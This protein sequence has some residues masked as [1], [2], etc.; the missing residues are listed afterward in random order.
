[1]ASFGIRIFSVSSCLGAMSRPM[2]L[3]PV[4]LPP[5]RASVAAKP[6]LTGSETAAVTIGMV[7][8]A[9]FAA[10]VPGLVWVTITS[11]WLCASSA[12]SFGSR[13]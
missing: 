8:V 3:S 12:A 10:W 2:L 13:A 6:L 4:M 7:A 9:C 1:M 5:G 11:T